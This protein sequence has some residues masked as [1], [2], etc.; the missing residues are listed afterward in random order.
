[1]KI[2]T[3]QENG[4]LWLAAPERSYGRQS[5]NEFVDLLATLK[6]KYPHKLMKF[7][8]QPVWTFNTNETQLMNDIDCFFM[9]RR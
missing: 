6:K 8:T 2:N 1:M 5:W 9:G 4:W 3:H 7:N